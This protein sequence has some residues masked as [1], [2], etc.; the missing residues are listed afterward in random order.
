MNDIKVRL[1]QYPI[2]WE[3]PEA[4]RSF[5]EDTLSEITDQCH[6]YVLPEMWT[7]GFSMNP[8]KLAEDMNGPTIKWMIW[9]ADQKNAAICGSLIIRSEEGF[10]NRFVFV[11][12]NGQLHYYDKRHCFSLA[13]ED[14]YFK[15]G[16]VRLLINYMG[17]RICPLICYDLRFPVWSRNQ[18]E[19]DVLLYSSQFPEKRRNAWNILLPARA[20]ENVCYVIGVNGIGT[21][22]N[23]IVYSGD[24]GAWD[25][26]GSSIGNL[27]SNIGSLEISLNKEKLLGF[28]RA[29]PFLKDRD[30][31]NIS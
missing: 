12:P 19:Y 18:D 22:G 4:N 21:D 28:R 20:I 9:M 23:G 30:K 13:K 17:W 24:S 11:E 7:T 31:F 2:F 29:Y 26:E 5:M 10:Y 27:E 14:Q 8:D 1:L 6:L 16:T 25:Y 15:S 3:D